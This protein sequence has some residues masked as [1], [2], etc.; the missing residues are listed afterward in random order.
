MDGHLLSTTYKSIS[1]QRQIAI[2]PFAAIV[3]SAGAP[4]LNGTPRAK[5][6]HVGRIIFSPE[7]IDPFSN[8]IFFE[9]PGDI[10]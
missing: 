7:S 8:R 1:A 2:N 9:F 10:F 6:V 4:P 5:I 3:R